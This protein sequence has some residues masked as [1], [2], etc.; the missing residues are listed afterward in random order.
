MLSVNVLR[1][2]YKRFAVR[3]AP[4]VRAFNRT[5]VGQVN[6]IPAAI[7]KPNR[8]LNA[9]VLPPSA[10]CCWT[11]PVVAIIAAGSA[12]PVGCEREELS[13]VTL[14]CR[15][16]WGIPNTTDAEVY[17]GTIPKSSPQEQSRQHTKAG[18]MIE[19][20]QSITANGVNSVCITRE[21]SRSV[22]GCNR[23]VAAPPANSVLYSHPCSCL[24]LRCSTTTLA[25][26]HYKLLHGILRGWRPL[27]E[28]R[29]APV[30]ANQQFE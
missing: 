25:P 24:M 12:H 6:H 21:K 18:S 15:H 28:Y 1:V 3:S 26:W 8:R 2:G 9:A 11:N 30:P 19:R 29:Q 10:A 4:S 17:K 13:S 7:V 16:E 20:T 27:L 22:P 23:A 5:V 14:W